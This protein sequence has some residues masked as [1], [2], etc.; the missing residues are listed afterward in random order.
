MSKGAYRP[1]TF[2]SK[3]VNNFNIFNT[4]N[5]EPGTRNRIELTS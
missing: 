3:A 1:A 5:Q 4:K 2:F